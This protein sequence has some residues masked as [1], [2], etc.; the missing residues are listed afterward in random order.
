MSASR[1]PDLPNYTYADYALWEGRWELIGGIPYAM[2]PSPIIGHQTISGNIHW[3]LK[4]IFIN[5]EKCLAV[6]A[7]DWKITENTVL[8]PDNLVVCH[9]LENE[10]YL[11][12][13]PIIIFEIL[14]KSA[15]RIDQTTKYNIYEQEGVKYYVIVDGEE[16]VAKVYELKNGKYIKM[17]DASDEIITFGIEE[18]GKVNFDFSQI[19]G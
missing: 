11:T 18:C 2:N 13:A 12:H 4:N 3:Q 8:C 6:Q 7:F 16:K 14:S 5:C 19:W 9:K 1:N 10:K 15:A 17:L